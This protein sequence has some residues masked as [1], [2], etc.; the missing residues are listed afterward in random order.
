MQADGRALSL[1]QIATTRSK[2]AQEAHIMFSLAPANPARSD[3]DWCWFLRG[4]GHA[5]DVVERALHQIGVMD[6]SG[7]ARW[8][9]SDLTETGAPVSV[10]F[11]THDR[12]LSIITEI[13]NPA[14]DPKTRFAAACDAITA[15]GGAAPD[16]AFREVISAAQGS[17]SLSYGARLGLRHDGDSLKIT[18]YV[19]LPAGASDL[20][21][22]LS[23]PNASATPV[24]HRDP[25]MLSY[26]TLTK[27]VALFCPTGSDACAHLITNL[28]SPKPVTLRYTLGGEDSLAF[29]VQQGA[30]LSTDPQLK[31]QLL[32]FERGISQRHPCLMDHLPPASAETAFHGG[33]WVSEHETAQPSLS[34]DVPAPWTG[35]DQ[36]G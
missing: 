17:S 36:P 24:P 16:T 35:A 6:H 2:S 3:L 34:F 12:A 19:E 28:A 5:G 25:T 22:L 31:A 11:S 8:Q 21:G 14:H 7:W 10:R 30:F 26:D 13:A 32:T 9:R 20:S 23:Q 27:Q 1:Q 29:R 18:L 4:F 33:I 15:L